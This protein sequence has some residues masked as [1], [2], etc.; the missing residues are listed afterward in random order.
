MAGIA[1]GE[2]QGQLSAQ[3]AEQVKGHADKGPMYSLAGIV[4][5]E[6]IFEQATKGVIEAL[7]AEQSSLEK[8]TDK[9]GKARRELLKQGLPVLQALLE[10]HGSAH[11]RLDKSS[12]AYDVSP[13]TQVVYTAA[14]KKAAGELADEI[15]RLRAAGAD[16]TTDGTEGS[17]VLRE[18]LRIG[19][20]LNRSNPHEAR[21]EGTALLLSLHGP[22]ASE[23][24]AA[25]DAARAASAG[26]RAGLEARGVMLG[27]FVP[28][29]EEKAEGL[30]RELE[31][32][33]V[34]RKAA[35]RGERDL[36]QL[37]VEQVNA[38]ILVTA[39]ALGGLKVRDQLRDLL[40]KT[41]Q[42]QRST[43]RVDAPAPTP[44]TP[45]TPGP[46]AAGTDRTPAPVI[47][48]NP[49]DASSPAAPVVPEVNA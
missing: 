13:G 42:G 3:V 17:K 33:L 8:A 2:L 5:S 11:R 16:V 12:A 43:D 34:S 6:Q 29:I 22:E 9:K 4:A 44:V 38:R 27:A 30:F 24:G 10:L 39:N 26:L 15:F 25:A 20:S 49:P 46:I 7:T 35:V 28:E 41:T 19:V 18:G 1:K 36:A 37:E 21:G 32:G 31:S 14:Q 45:G 47:V 48:V 40:P 23:T